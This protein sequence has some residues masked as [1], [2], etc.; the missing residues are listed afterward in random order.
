MNKNRI[1]Y[2]W[3]MRKV[4]LSS[5]QLS[6]FDKFISA[7]FIFF[8]TNSKSRKSFFSFSSSSFPSVLFFFRFGPF[9]LFGVSF[10]HQSLESDSHSGHEC[11]E[12]RLMCSIFVTTL[13]C[14]SKDV[15]RISQSQTKTSWWLWYLQVLRTMKIL[16]HCNQVMIIK[17]IDN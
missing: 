8:S 4:Q 11:L 5:M 2:G 13:F 12:S 10:R 1:N 16:H 14:L 6:V 9:F 17:H 15:W 7:F 3:K